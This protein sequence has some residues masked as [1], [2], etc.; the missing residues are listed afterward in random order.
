MG[1]FGYILK[2]WPTRFADGLDLGEKEKIKDDSMVL[3]LSNYISI[4]LL[5]TKLGQPEGEANWEG[6]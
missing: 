2:A 5:F 4:A 1:S 6:R 3:N